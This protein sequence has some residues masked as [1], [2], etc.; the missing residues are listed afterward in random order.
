M[1][2]AT[3][4][5]LLA[6][7]VQ[8]TPS[9]EAYRQ[10]DETSGR[11]VSYSW[12]EVGQRGQEWRR[13]LHAERLPSGARI[14]L[15]VPGGIAHVC[16][17]QAAL[18][19]G[20]VPVPM[21]VIDQPES[22]IYVLA[23]SGASLL[24]VDSCSRWS[25][26]ERFTSRLPNLKRVVCL[27]GEAPS[28]AGIA[29][30][31]T[32]WL[33]VASDREAQGDMPSPSIDSDA[34]AAI[35]Y[36]SGT[37]GRPKGVMLSHRNVVSNVYAVLATVPVFGRDVFLSFL[38]LSHTFERTVGYYLPMAVGATVVF[39][40]SI[41]LLM[42]DLATVRPTAL[43]SVP[44]I[45]ERVYARLRA[46]LDSRPVGRV[47]FGLA[48]SVRERQFESGA[49]KVRLSGAFVR[50]LWPLLDRVVGARVR[51]R[52][53]GRLRVA[54]S[55]GAPIPRLV[56]RTLLAVGVP[57]LQ[58]YG[59]TEASPVVACNTPADNH[60]DSVGRALPGIEVKIGA[61]DELLV[62]GPSV[63]VG[64]WKRPEETGRVL[65]PDGWLH[66]GDQAR[67]DDGRIVLEG[68]LKD[69][70]VTSTGEKIAPV[71]LES[72]ILADPVFEQVMVIGEGK[73]YIAALVVLNRDGWGKQV[74]RL[75]LRAEDTAGLR[76]PSARAW[77]LKRIADAI[78]GFPA[79]AT[80]RA[81][82]LSLDPWTVD[83]GLITPTLKPKRPAIA[84]RFA[85]EIAEL[86]R[87]HELPTPEP[88][89]EH[90]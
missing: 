89:H 30:T 84:A 75:G 76:S 2:P 48:V 68:R 43:V 41:P 59:L 46:N 82:C 55:G 14:A 8:A 31:L 74:A 78:R 88:A 11:W 87:G 4:P 7:R 69:I 5:E 63:M 24:F 52:F 58:G 45:Y 34:L 35:V 64:Y 56:S 16:M 44:R 66:T 40:R 71:D 51:A 29:R 53:G 72:A 25:L 38:P 61:Q 23:D 47:L 6:M 62:R 77:A 33:R 83:S 70:I 36:T 20:F 57:L 67:L 17:D 37:T 26:L 65:E 21:H 81:V 9:G 13:A 86:Y 27:S 73:P 22:L 28:P 90:S 15:L 39:A 60:P 12:S 10:F 19:L 49:W 1:K 3:L 85:V 32:Q 18:A 54:V 42:A 79:Y 80:P 50:A